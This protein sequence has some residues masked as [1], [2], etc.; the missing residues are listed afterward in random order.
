[1]LFIL[2]DCDEE[3]RKKIKKKKKRMNDEIIMPMMYVASRGS[4]GEQ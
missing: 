4:Q 2:F 3:R 1:M